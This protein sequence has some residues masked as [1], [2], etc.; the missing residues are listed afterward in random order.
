[1]KILVVVNCQIQVTAVILISITRKV[2]YC[3]L[4]L[5]M[6]VVGNG[7]DMIDTHLLWEDM[8]NYF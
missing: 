7:A 4:I 6:T 3:Y 8:G 5:V 2:M 1:M